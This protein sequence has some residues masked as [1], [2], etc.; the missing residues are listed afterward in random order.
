VGNRNVQFFDALKMRSIK[1]T[2][3]HHSKG[4]VPRLEPAQLQASELDERRR[5]IR[6]IRQELRRE[7]RRD[8]VI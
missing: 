6:G 3:V 8:M 4:D 1:N 5:H 2:C 7:K